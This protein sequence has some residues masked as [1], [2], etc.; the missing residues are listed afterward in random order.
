MLSAEMLFYDDLYDHMASLGEDIVPVPWWR[1]RGGRS[2]G[3]ERQRE[4]VRER[5]CAHVN[6]NE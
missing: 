3:T 4:W 1:R 2:R 6:A 5:E